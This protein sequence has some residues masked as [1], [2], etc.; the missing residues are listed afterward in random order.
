MCMCYVALHLMCAVSYIY[1]FA[2]ECSI[3]FNVYI[4]HIKNNAMPSILIKIKE[5]LFTETN[6]LLAETKAEIVAKNES[7]SAWAYNIKID[8]FYCRFSLYIFMYSCCYFG[9]IRFRVRSCLYIFCACIV[10]TWHTYLCS[11]DYV[12]YCLFVVFLP[13]LLSKQ[14][15]FN[16]C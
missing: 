9:D 6:D 3:Y 8:T 12:W 15:S 13:Y 11:N 4:M 10:Y 14:L 7:K 1:I 16:L 2:A 5:N